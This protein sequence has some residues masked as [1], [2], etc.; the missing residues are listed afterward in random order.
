M[1]YVSDACALYLGTQPG[2]RD[3]TVTFSGTPAAAVGSAQHLVDRGLAQLSLFRKPLLP[4]TSGCHSF[5]PTEVHDYLTMI[6]PVMY[7]WILQM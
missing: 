1:A 5:C 4:T 2:T 3:D 6:F 7:W